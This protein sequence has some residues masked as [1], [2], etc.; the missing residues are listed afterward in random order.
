MKSWGLLGLTVI[1]ILVCMLIVGLHYFFVKRMRLYFS[2]LKA[3]EK[4]TK[5]PLASHEREMVGENVALDMKARLF[6]FRKSAALWPKECKVICVISLIFAVLYAV[7]SSPMLE[8]WKN[9]VHARVLLNFLSLYFL[10]FAPIIGVVC[11]KLNGKLKHKIQQLEEIIA[12][13]EK[14]FRIQDARGSENDA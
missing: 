1:A 10:L 3:L 2:M 8:G 11:I 9:D 6:T 5:H 14:A 4:S 12:Q 13:Q 7:D